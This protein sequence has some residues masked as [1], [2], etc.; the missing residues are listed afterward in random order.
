MCIRDREYASEVIP[1][2]AFWE[3]TAKNAFVVPFRLVC[4]AVTEPLV[5]KFDDCVDPVTYAVAGRSVPT[6]MAN[7]S[8]ELP[9]PRNVA[10]DRSVAP[11]PAGVI[12]ITNPS[13][14]SPPYV[15]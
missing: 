14:G 5:G 10:Y 9:P 11:F 15:V 7:A 2:V 3:I 13:N 6:A 8:S 4:S 12:S 1:V